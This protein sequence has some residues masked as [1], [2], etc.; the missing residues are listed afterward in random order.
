VNTQT[1]EFKSVPVQ[2]KLLLKPLL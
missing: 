1:Q 2:N